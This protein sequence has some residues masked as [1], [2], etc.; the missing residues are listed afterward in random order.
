MLSVRM[1]TG[2]LGKLNVPIVILEGYQL[3]LAPGAKLRAVMVLS[4]PAVAENVPCVSI[5]K[6]SYRTAAI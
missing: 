4:S 3:K 5:N 2:S 6:A 1:A